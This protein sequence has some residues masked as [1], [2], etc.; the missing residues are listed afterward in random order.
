MRKGE[1][2]HVG[3][4]RK[5]KYA[6]MKGENHNINPFLLFKNPRLD[7]QKKMPAYNKTSVQIPWGFYHYQDRE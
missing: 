4:V 7:I 3:V 1:G 5:V 6:C 2:K